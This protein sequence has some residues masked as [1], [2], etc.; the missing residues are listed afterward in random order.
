VLGD[1][2]CMYNKLTSLEGFPKEVKGNVD[3]KYNTV[4][5]T[6]QDVR[7]I[8]IVHKNVYT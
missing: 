8:C 2:N 4:K 6:Q 1:F 7:N 5:F 3:I